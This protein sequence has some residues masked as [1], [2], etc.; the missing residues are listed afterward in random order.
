MYVD[1]CVEG[2]HRLME[3]NWHEPINLGREDL[4]SIN[5]LVSLVE[6]IAPYNVKRTY[7]LDAPKGVRGRNSDNTLIKKVLGWEPSITM[8]EGMQ[9]TY[10]W[11]YGE[12]TKNA[13]H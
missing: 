6:E 3:S 5:E 4:I 1:D 8:K 10:A 13:T 12:M 9:K 7:K 2:I 11:I